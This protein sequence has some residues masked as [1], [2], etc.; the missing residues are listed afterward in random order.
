MPTRDSPP[1]LLHTIKADDA[2]DIFH[3]ALSCCHARCLRQWGL[4]KRRYG[5]LRQIASFGHRRVE[6]QCPGRVEGMLKQRAWLRSRKSKRQHAHFDI[7]VG[8]VAE[9]RSDSFRL[10]LHVDL[11]NF[12]LLDFILLSRRFRQRLCIRQCSRERSSGCLEGW[13]VEM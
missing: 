12:T 2:L 7:E 13:A 9:N 10:S 11:L 1:K 3:P 4:R 5:G 8:R 6:P